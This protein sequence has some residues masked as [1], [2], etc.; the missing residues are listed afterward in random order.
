M[1]S[2]IDFIHGNNE[3]IIQYKTVKS[4]KVI[5]QEC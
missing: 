4:V 1:M 2:Y 5:L 3:L